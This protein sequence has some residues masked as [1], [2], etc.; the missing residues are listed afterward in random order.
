VYIDANNPALPDIEKILDRLGA[1][2]GFSVAS[3]DWIT[4]DVSRGGP[5]SG[6]AAGRVHRAAKGAVRERGRQ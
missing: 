2:Y 1:P 4:P 6:R 3:V 5:E